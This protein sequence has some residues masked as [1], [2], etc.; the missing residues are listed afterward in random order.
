LLYSMYKVEKFFLQEVIRQEAI[1]I[2]TFKL[3]Q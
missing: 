2:I 1:K 3:D